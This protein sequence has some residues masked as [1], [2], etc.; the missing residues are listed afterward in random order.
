MMKIMNANKVLFCLMALV[1]V[2]AA[3]YTAEA[4]AET[5]HPPELLEKSYL[6]EVARHLYRWYMDEADVFRATHGKEFTFWVR[7]LHPKLDPG[8]KSRLGEII[9]P[10]LGISVRVKKADYTIEELDLVVK[11]DT[12][13][14][15]NVSRISADEKPAAGTAK[16]V[17][18]YQE[19]R[20]YLFRTRSQVEFPDDELLLRLRLAVR[21]RLL[22]DARDHG[23]EIPTGDQVV[24]FSPISP[25]ANELWVFWE[26]GRLL[27]RFASDL[28]LVN[29]VVWQYEDLAVSLFDIDEQVVV[30][31]DEVAGSNA[32]MTR[33]QVGRALFNCVILGRRLVLNPS[34]VEKANKE[35]KEPPAGDR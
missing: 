7:G 11:T 4:P 21:K 2:P 15:T 28:D 12:F 30:S 25:V 5:S 18:D 24:H 19:M 17:V 1:L 34:E 29:P 20:D 13:K 10:E 33:D 8:D 14:I 26:N 23:E 31:L 22:K 27:I 32:Y 35:L 9:L 16:V 3:V 6:Y